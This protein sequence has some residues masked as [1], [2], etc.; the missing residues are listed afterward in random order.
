MPIFS[1]TG[2]KENAEASLELNSDN[3]EARKG[4]IYLEKSR[5]KDFPTV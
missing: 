2:G 4:G 3:W 5:I 1:G